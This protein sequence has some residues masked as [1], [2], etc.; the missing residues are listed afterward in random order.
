MRSPLLILILFCHFPALLARDQVH[1]ITSFL[2]AY[3]FTCAIAGDAARVENLV[4]SSVEPHDYQL[5]PGDL[6]R[7]QTADLIVVNGL[8]LEPWL[9]KVEAA[10]SGRKKIA[11]LSDRIGSELLIAASGD[12]INPHIWLDPALVA[13]S[14]TNI[15]SALVTLD[16]LNSQ[17]YAHNANA[18]IQRLHDLDQTIKSLLQPFRGKTFVT[19]HDAFPYFARHYELNLVGVVEQVAEVPPSARELTKLFNVIRREKVR[20]IFTEPLDPPRLAR[21][22]AEDAGIALGVLDTIETG[23]ID[24]SAYEKA[25]L[26][27]AA[28]LASLLSK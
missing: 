17:I 18:F 8:G 10:V 13:I 11:T 19:Y 21:Q 27:N 23:P 24:S 12:E 7:L 5:S 1:V 16:P 9:E 28:A 26:Q 14:A 2:P 20:A 3:C 25:M 15:L 4:S 6:R 22:I